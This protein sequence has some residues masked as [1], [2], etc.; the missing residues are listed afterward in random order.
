MNKYPYNSESDSITKEMFV[1]ELGE[2]LSHT[3]EQVNKCTLSE[4]GNHVIIT[5]DNG[6]ER[7]VNI[8]CDGWLAIIRDVCA[9]V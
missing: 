1:Q 5:Y 2:L 8:E 4:D 7:N 9:H 6:Y 3:R